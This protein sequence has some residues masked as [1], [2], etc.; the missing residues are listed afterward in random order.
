MLTLAH[1][2]VLPNPRRGWATVTSFALQ[3]AALAV[4]LLIPILQPSL[5][6]RLDFAP[7]PVSISLAP[8]ATQSVPHNSGKASIDPVI[9]VLTMP[10]SIPLITD[11]G[12]DTTTSQDADPPCPQ[13]VPG[14]GPGSAVPGPINMIGL[15]VPMPPKPASKPPRV[16]VM[17]DGYLIHRVQP[18]YPML[19]KQIR[20][21]G[22]VEIAAVIS[23]QGTIENLQIVSG[24]PM[25]VRAALD[26]VKQWRYRPYILNGDP[27][28]VD[29]KITVIFTLGGN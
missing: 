4:A 10:P 22:P 29:T 7:R 20:V 6:P 17:M 2:S 5:L 19:A 14:A 25:L 26:A 23:K 3:G 28:E 11:S 18:D 16:S 8:S 9:S 13:C 24:H 12:P 15:P 21:H 1:E 27:I